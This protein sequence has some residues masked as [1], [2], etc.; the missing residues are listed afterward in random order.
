MK[1]FLSNFISFTKSQRTQDEVKD[2]K[3]QTEILDIFRGTYLCSF[4][5]AINLPVML[6]YG[7]IIVD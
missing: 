3:K 2:G 4:W 5:R 1:V 7:L 6:L